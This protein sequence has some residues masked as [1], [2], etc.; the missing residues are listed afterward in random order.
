MYFTL[1][2]DSFLSEQPD[3]E[4]GRI[5]LIIS[6]LCVSGFLGF[7]YW[8]IF[9]QGYFAQFSIY[10]PDYEFIEEDPNNYGIT[11]NPAT[12]KRSNETV[13]LSLF[14]VLY[15]FISYLLLLIQQ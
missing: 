12:C 1:P 3:T 8:L 4:M 2:V 15:F 6:A 7:L 9:C 14:C 10:E 5:T 13:S 11:A